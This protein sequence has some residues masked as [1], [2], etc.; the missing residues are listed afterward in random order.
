MSNV[1][2]LRNANA[3]VPLGVSLG[4]ADVVAVSGPLS[5]SVKLASGDI[6]EA[7]LAMAFTYAPVP[8]DEVLVIG[9]P[10]G[11]FVIG[12]LSGQ[13]KSTLAIPGDVEIRAVGGH[14]QLS[15]DKGVTVEAPEV[16][17]RANALR[18]IAGTLTQTLTNL[19]QHVTDLWST[20][21]GKAH[22]IVD[23]S[24]HQQSKTATVL[25]E[26]DIVINGRAIH[27]G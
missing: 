9:G 14:L 18:M 19:R 23:G 27:L 20:R 16:D 15:G 26:E 22:T 5:A 10:E 6:H 25:T 17:V 8:G 1:T 24:T 4:S 11:H 3:P 13:G 2:Q 12:V 21:T 7:R